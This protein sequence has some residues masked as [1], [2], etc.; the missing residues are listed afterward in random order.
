MFAANHRNNNSIISNNYKVIIITIVIK[1]QQ[2]LHCH[3]DAAAFAFG[4]LGIHAVHMRNAECMLSGANCSPVVRPCVEQASSG[5]TMH[6]S[7][8]TLEAIRL[9]P[10]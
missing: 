1:V 10:V 9:E 4:Q 2:T 6:G 7:G 5:T 3:T 8:W